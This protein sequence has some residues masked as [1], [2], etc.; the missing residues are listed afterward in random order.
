LKRGLYTP[1]V[2]TLSDLKE[3]YD[4]DA[5][6]KKGMWAFHSKFHHGHG[7]CAVQTNKKCDWVVGILWN[8]FA[9]GMEW[10]VGE[11]K[12]IDDQIRTTD[13]E[14]LKRSSDVVMVFTGD[15]HPYKQ[16]WHTIK[17]TIDKEFPES[18]LREKGIMD[19][20]TLYSSLIYSIA[21]RITIHEI[22]GIKLDYHA[23]CGRDRWRHV[24]YTEWLK[25]RFGLEQELLDAVR[26]KY[27][28]VLSG[29]RHRIPPKYDKRIKKP[30]ILPE[31]QTIEEVNK[32]ISDIP[33]L[34]AVHF[35][36]EC[37][38]IHV[39]FQFTDKYWW[40]EGLKLCKS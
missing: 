39:K 22:Y 27:G 30:L 23:S 2:F 10:M 40:S 12:D 9:A 3:I 5:H 18:F 1:V 31:F 11:T 25:E 34:K 19:E 7:S 6:G 35:S 28:N 33:D 36:R 37:D 16:H 17:S 14:V 38:W 29:M 32:Y 13:I 21:V 15:Y 4:R 20:L 24:K 26:D 8:N